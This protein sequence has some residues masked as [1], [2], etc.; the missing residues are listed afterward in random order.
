M[1]NNYHPVSCQLHSELELYAMNRTRVSIETDNPDS[2][3]T[4]QIT[5][6]TSHD[7][8]EYVI[9]KTESHQPQEVRLDKIRSITPA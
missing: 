3:L 6:I 7:K 9:I 4:G 8:A 1:T 5:D 2:S